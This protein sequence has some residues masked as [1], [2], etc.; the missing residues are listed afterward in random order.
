[1]TPEERYNKLESYGAAHEMLLEA[2]GRFPKEMWQFRPAEGQW[3]IHEILI[4]ITDSEANSYVRCRR[5]V[6]EPGGVIQGY[7]E[8]QW[9]RALRY[10]D[11]PIEEALE[12]F[13]HLRQSSYQ[14]IKRLPESVWANTGIHTEDG[15]ISLD[16]WLDTYERHVS[17]HIQQMQINYQEWKRQGPPP[18]ET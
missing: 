3:T 2:L 8:N 5:L 1:M 16:D 17:E 15:Q 4:H 7:D 13:K 6:A 14:L 12:L 9:A 11:L 18:M 10:H